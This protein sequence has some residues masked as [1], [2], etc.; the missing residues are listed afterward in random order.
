MA[1]THE[2]GQPRQRR[3]L[4]LAG[5]AAGILALLALGSWPEGLAARELVREDL[6]QLQS[7]GSALT[8]DEPGRMRSCAALSRIVEDLRLYVDTSGAA[9][10][11]ALRDELDSYAV[12]ADE[13]G[14]S[15]TASDEQLLALRE[16]G[17][18]IAGMFEEGLSNSVLRASRWRM[19]LFGWCALL[20]ALIL[21]GARR[22]ARAEQALAASERERALQAELQQALARSEAARAEAE[23]ARCVAEESN[24][25]K[26]GFLANMS[27]EIRT[28]MTSI[29]GFAEQLL[30]PGVDDESR[31]ESIGMIRRNADH[32][33]HL[34]DDV[35]D[36]SRIEA[37]RLELDLLAC[38]LFAVLSEVRAVMATRAARKG[39]EFRIDLPRPVP[40][41]IVTDATRLKQ[42]LLN[43]VGNA[44]KFTEHGF[45]RV[46]LG[47]REA[48]G[49]KAR[50]WFRVEDTG[51]GLD[52]QAIE[53]LFRPFSQADETIQ[54]R[55][56]GTG[57]GLSISAHLVERLGGKIR[58]EGT[59]GSGSAFSFEI[60]AAL[61]EGC[62]WRGAEGLEG[63]SVR[64]SDTRY[65]PRAP[66][67]QA[68][69]LLAEDGE[70]NRRLIAHLLK[71]VGLE[72]LSVGNGAEA[73]EEV[74][75]A[76]EAGRPFDLVL[77]DMQM[78]VLDGYSA[79]QR[80][81][82]SGLRTPIMAL[83][84]NAMS[85]DRQRCLDIGCDEFCAK[86]IDFDQFFAAL[87][88]CL[89][90]RG[91]HAPAA[92]PQPRP[93]E[94][95]PARDESFA[96]LVELFVRELGEDL[97]QLHELLAR[98]DLS[99]LARL[100][101]QLKGSCGSYGFPELSRRAAELERCVK[102]GAGKDALGSALA[103]FGESCAGVRSSSTV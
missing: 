89:A 61:V 29:L 7:S 3:Y 25:L 11:K 86:P 40:D 96:Q 5:L 34:I 60:E 33:M 79:V 58:A 103:A 18:R 69:V 14:S 13:L 74:R 70:D 22:L 19:V 16:R 92:L 23:R 93:V 46:S 63:S 15:R 55:F 67:R 2:R 32:L 12:S 77:M 80:L 66:V 53:R 6:R 36:I 57:L 21:V 44:I 59:P 39:L 81:R 10:R 101:H 82:E 1:Q 45:V 99:G 28:P 90:S 42:V 26:S 43:L 52:P 20:M 37:G 76:R 50:L 62:A 35:L 72:L 100:A 88:R 9:D 97:Q 75:K 68:R 73:L 27:H 85:S 94:S 51:I 54:K 31:L 56:G 84:A 24:R 65:T 83:T 78:P 38:S 49:G 8:P 91:A 98:E 102:D 48:R 30:E 41:G 71:R 64:L 17:T 95:V 87:D 4:L 47:C